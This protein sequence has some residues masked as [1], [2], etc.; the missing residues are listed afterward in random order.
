MG[1]RVCSHTHREVTDTANHLD[2]LGG[3]RQLAWRQVEVRGWVAAER[4][5]VLDPRGAIADDDLLQFSPRVRG[6]RQMC[7]WRHRGVAQDVDNDLVRTLTRGPT[8][9]VRDRDIRRFQGL[10]LDERLAQ[11]LF[12]LRSAGREELEREAPTPREDVGDLG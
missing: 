5:D 2:K 1:F 11:R 6:T 8:G 4:E 12:G 7:H 3:V 10:E 9:A